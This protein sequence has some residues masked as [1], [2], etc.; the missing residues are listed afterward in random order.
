MGHTEYKKIHDNL[1]LERRKKIQEEVEAILQTHKVST[2][3][4]FF[5]D[6]L[7]MVL[8]LVA[9]RNPL[10]SWKKQKT[11][12]THARTVGLPNCLIYFD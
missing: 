8:I 12:N 2:L 4:G 10:R 9:P 3:P 5:L 7:L 11:K 6:C 1:H